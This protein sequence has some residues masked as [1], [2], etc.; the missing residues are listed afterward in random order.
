M[1][2]VVAA[3]VQQVTQARD[4]ARVEL[5]AHPEAVRAHPERL[6]LGHEVLLPVEEV[7]GLV[8]EAVAVARPRVLDEQPF[9][10]ARPE[11]LDQPEDPQVAQPVCLSSSA[12]AA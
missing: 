11:A 4:P 6:D 8:G 9:G 5:A 7:R 10:P 3:G 2:H 1:H 12:T